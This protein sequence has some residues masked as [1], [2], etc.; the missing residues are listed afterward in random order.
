MIQHV[1]IFFAQ[2]LKTLSKN[3]LSKCNFSDFTLLTSKFTKFFMSFLKDKSGFLQSL[4]HSS[5]LWEV[6]PQ[7][8]FSWNFICYWE[9]QHIKCK[10]SYLPL[11]ALK[12]TKFLMSFLEPRA[13]FSSNFAS[14][15]SVMRHNSSVLFHLK[16]YMLWTKGADQSANFQTLDFSH[17]N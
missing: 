10:F 11:I 7:H 12:S 8:F 5:M 13:S 2:S 16:L 3:S 14:L 17:E 4:N 1:H 9:K 6:T 15:F